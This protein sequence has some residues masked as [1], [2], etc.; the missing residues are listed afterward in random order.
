MNRFVYDIPT[1]LFFGEG[2]I[3]HLRNL[4]SS[5]GKNILFIYGGG[6]IKRN[7][8]YDKIHST[9]KGFNL[10]ELDGVESNPK[11]KLVEVGISLCLDH[12]IDL[13]LA[14]GGGSTIDTGKLISAGAVSK[15]SPW[16]LVNNPKLITGSLPLITIG[17]IAG[18]GSEMN[19]NAV[20]SNTE[21][22][23]KI[24]FYSYHFFP[25]F[26]ICDPTYTYTVPKV[27]TA[28]GAIDTM[29]HVIEMYFQKEQGTFIQDG[30]SEA[31]MK[32]CLH[33]LPIVLEN[34]EDF[35]SRANL[36]WASTT[37][38]NRL[39]SFGKRGDYSLHHIEHVL[40]AH[41]NVSHALGIAILMPRWLA[42][43]LNDETVP[44]FN[45]FA[46]NVLSMKVSSIPFK[47][48][49]EAVLELYNLIANSG[50]PVTLPDVLITDNHLFQQIAKESEKMLTN[51]FVA[52]NS[53]DINQILED[54]MTP[55]IVFR[56]LN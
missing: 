5:F 4:A 24:N 52:L 30:I 1:K 2:Q 7:G 41:Y 25:V 47:T 40:S 36:M 17:T 14:V 3:K 31:V 49:K 45:K 38:L 9:L 22:N 54:S 51:S 53:S 27:L 12:Q 29:S 37:A 13:I 42:Y 46:K 55:G 56:N 33:Y 20:I 39:T 21:T 28:A 26:A 15:E 19:G 6:S 18:T 43:I 48:A 34:P 16:D 44:L 32:A 35:E 50:L 23:E 11:I 10:I 8:L